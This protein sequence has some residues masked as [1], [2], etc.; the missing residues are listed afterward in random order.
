VT[1]ALAPDSLRA[2]RRVWAGRLGTTE[3]SLER[4]GVSALRWEAIP[5]ASVVR[6]A[7]TTVVGAPSWAL[8]KL[9]SL[10]PSSLLDPESLVSALEGLGPTLF[11][12]AGLSYIDARTFTPSTGLRA[13][14]AGRD[15]VE[16]ML[17][18]LPNAERDESGLEQMDRWWVVTAADGAPV[19]VAGCETWN[20]ALAHLGV[21][22]V[23]DARGTGAGAAAAS[24]AIAQ[25]LGEGLVVQWRGGVD[26][27]ASRRLGERLGAVP[28]GEQVTV[29]LAG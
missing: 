13:T 4:A 5:A 20:S 9:E 21:A 8:E 2:I 10:D 1:T 17:R 19:A 7:G 11:G 16:R 15:D 23:P 3:A 22:V 29:D 27:H 18:A 26:N 12:A 6:I 25:S 28:L 24:A 14:A